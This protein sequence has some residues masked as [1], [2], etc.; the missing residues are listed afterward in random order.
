MPNVS[1]TDASSPLHH[2][3]P[4]LPAS[5]GFAGGK[6][7]VSAGRCGLFNSLADDS[8]FPMD[9]VRLGLRGAHVVDGDRSMDRGI[10]HSLPAVLHSCSCA[11]ALCET[12]AGAD[13]PR[14]PPTAGRLG[15]PLQESLPLPILQRS[16]RHGSAGARAPSARAFAADPLAEKAWL[17]DDAMSNPPRPF[18]G[19][20]YRESTLWMSNLITR[21]ELPRSFHH[22]TCR[23]HRRRRH[24]R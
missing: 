21:Q 8:Q 18:G 20:W 3:H 10:A 4:A 12:P 16:H 24:R 2:R 5:G 13:G 17:I 22:P 7:P 9:D 1:S 19:A 6:W 11:D 23:G 15:D 14:K